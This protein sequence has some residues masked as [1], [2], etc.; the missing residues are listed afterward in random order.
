MTKYTVKNCPNLL[1]E[2]G[3]PAC[4]LTWNI[5]PLNEHFD[6]YTY[7]QDVSDCLLKQIVAKCREYRNNYCIANGVQLLIGEILQIACFKDQIV[8]TIF[9]YPVPLTTLS[10]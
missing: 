4:A 2:K 10:Y 8:D 6:K 7:C 9:H 5:T 1:F 3:I